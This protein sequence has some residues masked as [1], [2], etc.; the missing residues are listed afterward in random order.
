MRKVVI[1]KGSYSQEPSQGGVLLA[2]TITLLFLSFC[3]VSATPAD[4]ALYE[5]LVTTGDDNA[6]RMVKDV[7]GVSYVLTMSWLP[8][9]Y[10]WGIWGYNLEIGSGIP[11]SGLVQV[12]MPDAWDEK[13]RC[14][15]MIDPPPGFPPELVKITIRAS[16]PLR[17]GDVVSDAICALQLWFVE[18][19]TQQPPPPTLGSKNLLTNGDFSQGGE[20]WRGKKVPSSTEP[21][22]V[23]QPS[24]YGQLDYDVYHTSP[25]SLRMDPI[26]FD[27]S[28]EVWYAVRF[29]VLAG[30]AVC[31]RGWIRAGS[32]PH[33]WAGSG[34]RFGLDFRREPGYITRGVNGGFSHF[35]EAGQEGWT[36]HEILTYVQPGEDNVMLWLQGYPGDAQAPGWWDELELYIYNVSVEEPVSSPPTIAEIPLQNGLE[37]V[38]WELDVDPYISDPDTAESELR[39]YVSSEYVNVRGHSLTFLYPEGIVRDEVL[40]HVDD[41]TTTVK[42][43]IDVTVTP[44]NDPPVLGEII[45]ITVTEG[46]TT[47]LDLAPLVKDPDDEPQTLEWDVHGAESVKAWF[48]ESSLLVSAPHGSAGT[49]AILLTVSDSGGLSDSQ[50]VAIQVEANLTALVEESFIVSD[51]C[52]LDSSGKPIWSVAPGIDLHIHGEIVS[53]SGSLP[54]YLGVSLDSTEKEAAS[55]I[56]SYVVEWNSSTNRCTVSVDGS[57]ETNLPM[58][59]W[60]IYGSELV[61]DFSLSFGGLSQRGVWK[62]VLTIL[63]SNGLR[64]AAPAV[65][66]FY[67]DSKLEIKG[68]HSPIT[69]NFTPCQTSVVQDLHLDLLANFQGTVLV[70][71]ADIKQEGGLCLAIS[72]DGAMWTDGVEIPTIGGN[73]QLSLSICPLAS[74][75]C[76]D[77]VWQGS[78]RLEPFLTAISPSRTNATGPSIGEIQLWVDRPKDPRSFN[79]QTFIGGNSPV[80]VACVVVTSQPLALTKYLDWLGPQNYIVNFEDLSGSSLSFPIEGYVRVIDLAG[81]EA[82]KSFNFSVQPLQQ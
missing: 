31:A 6:Y 50:S 25:P 64:E 47:S 29:P 46:E 57:A 74:S 66:Y 5:W 49:D 63:D 70:K 17:F 44:V 35:V 10:T 76:R 58:F 80:G 2:A 18:P 52:I 37:D 81:K 36:Q 23:G 1:P 68:E 43:I 27:P 53:I 75:P 71:L 62:L 30:Q 48:E 3:S 16:N 8:H 9:P 13:F 73:V 28:R 24:F 41:G 54:D 79:L 33:L 78:L 40:V 7:G 11:D 72:A 15:T 51:L 38:L 82:Y 61:L 59:D 42:G 34:C 22:V 26:T 69:L 60:Q 4:Y 20:P 45:G 65:L 77:G 21:P 39:V 55:L 19:T 56:G 32:P 12:P 14:S 67:V